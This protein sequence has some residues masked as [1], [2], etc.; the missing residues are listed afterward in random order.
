MTLQGVSLSSDAFFPFRDNIDHAS[1]YGVKYVTQPGGSRM[2]DAVT[3]ACDEYGM[4]QCHHGVNSSTTK[5][6]ETFYYIVLCMV[7]CYA[8][9]AI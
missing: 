4:V 8:C 1:K 3:A 5:M 2:D 6:R 7:I 9:N